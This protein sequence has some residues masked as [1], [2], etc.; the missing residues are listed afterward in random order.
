[1]RLIIINLLLNLTLCWLFKVLTARRRSIFIGNDQTNATRAGDLRATLGGGVEKRPRARAGHQP[2][3]KAKCARLRNIWC[4]NGKSL[5]VCDCVW[6]WYRR[7]RGLVSVPSLLGW[8]GNEWCGK[9]VRYR[10][11]APCAFVWEQCQRHP[12]FPPLSERPSPNI[13]TSSPPSIPSNRS[14]NCYS[15]RHRHSI[16]RRGMSRPFH[17]SN[18]R[19]VL[20]RIGRSPPGTK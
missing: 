5:V 8:P 3:D 7:Y 16:R 2:G 4:Q 13:I 15:E 18:V 6:W 19:Y 12:K 9:N 10:S 17:P 11:H 14:E 20:W 1:M